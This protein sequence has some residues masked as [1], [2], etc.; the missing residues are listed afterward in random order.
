MSPYTTPRAAS[1][2]VLTR[3]RPGLG[4][5][6]PD[7]GAGFFILRGKAQQMLNSS[8]VARLW[9][10]PVANGGLGQKVFRLSRVVLE[11]ATQMT[12]VH[13]NVVLMRYIRRPPHFAQ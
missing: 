12:H 11:L 4:R 5:Y 10:K 7:I 9:H 3:L 13:A 1:V 2:N 8:R 6:E